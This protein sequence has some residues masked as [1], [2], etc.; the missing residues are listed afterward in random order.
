NNLGVAAL[1][2]DEN[3]E[4]IRHFNRALLLAPRMAFAWANLGTT[5]MRLDMNAEAEAALRESARLDPHE[6]VALT[7]LERLYARQGAPELAEAMRRLARQARFQ[8][9]FV[10]YDLGLTA[11]R[12]DR[13]KAAVK[14][15]EKALDGLPELVQLRAD[16]ARAYFADEQVDKAKKT[17]RQAHA[18]ATSDEERSLVKRTLLA[19]TKGEEE[20][21]PAP[22][23]LKSRKLKAR[24]PLPD[25]SIQ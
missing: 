6:V 25:L 17:F 8:N 7:S 20:E 2:R 13:A 5:M 23:A 19:L 12:E 9:P 4:A 10:H 18:L 24:R 11:L 14:H 1:A 15:L 16:L 22:L 3:E 21:P